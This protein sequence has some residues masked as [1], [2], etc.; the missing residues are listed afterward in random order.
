MQ[1]ILCKAKKNDNKEWVEGHLV[2]ST[3]NKFFIIAEYDDELEK[4][5]IY[6]VD[7]NTICRYTGL[8]DCNNT[9][10]WEND[11]VEIPSEFGNFTVMWSQTEARWEM[12]NNEDDY[13]VDF[14]NFWSYQVEVISDTFIRS[15]A[16][17]ED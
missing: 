8:T 10:I 12:V 16:W 11:I 17:Q 2:K 1:D 13:I 15:E 7:E 3:N 4:L 6:E 5:D 14:D 9:K